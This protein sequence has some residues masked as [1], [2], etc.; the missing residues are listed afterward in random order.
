MV[1][2]LPVT[3]THVFV[4][5]SCHLSFVLWMGLRRLALYCASGDLCM[6]LYTAAIE[7]DPAGE[8]A[9]VGGGASLLVTWVSPALPDG[10]ALS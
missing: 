10:P 3:A 1:Q 8:G 4:R 2:R 7:G 5:V 6:G 9:G